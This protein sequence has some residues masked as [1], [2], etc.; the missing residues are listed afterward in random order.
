MTI[1][2]LMILLSMSLSFS[3]IAEDKK[4]EE[5]KT[6]E[7][8]QKDKKFDR[9][10]LTIKVGDTI[11]FKNEETNVTHNV[12]SMGPKNAFDI[13]S[14]KPKSSSKVEFKEEGETEIECAIHPTMKLKVK[15]TK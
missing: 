3:I 13:Q 6:V 7:V 2:K 8:I 11:D 5:K 12:F 14:Q 15:V 1:H 9:N 10:E 4:T